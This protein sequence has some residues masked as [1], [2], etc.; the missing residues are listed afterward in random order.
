[1]VVFIAATI[2]LLFALVSILLVVYGPFVVGGG[3]GGGFAANWWMVT[4]Y[5]VIATSL[6]V[7][8]L[9]HRATLAAKL[10]K[11]PSDHETH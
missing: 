1:M 11:M 2:C 10:S 6:V 4:S 5:L 3:G 8:G 7:A 9:R